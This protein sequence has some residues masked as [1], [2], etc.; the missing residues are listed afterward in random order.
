MM[1]VA[2]NITGSIKASIGHGS[3]LLKVKGSV[4]SSCSPPQG[5]KG[6]ICT[7]GASKDGGCFIVT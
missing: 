6:F 5:A 3:H 2:V 7:A 4:H 1:A